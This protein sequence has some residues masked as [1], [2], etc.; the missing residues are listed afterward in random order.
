VSEDVYP[1]L[2]NSVIEKSKCSFHLLPE[3]KEGII[4]SMLIRQK[5]I[6]YKPKTSFEKGLEKTIQWWF[7]DNWINIEKSAKFN[8]GAS[9]AVR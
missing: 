8:P 5:I 9:A 2:L 4:N 7:D 6:G 3:D 1:D